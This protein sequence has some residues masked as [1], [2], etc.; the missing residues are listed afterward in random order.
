MW[1]ARPDYS[2]PNTLPTQNRLNSGYAPHGSQQQALPAGAFVNPAFARS[3][4]G[5]LQQGYSV[6]SAQ[7]LV[8]N[9]KPGDHAYSPPRTIAGHKRKLDA[10][11]GP[12]RET[13]P[14]PPAAPVVPAF[15]GSLPLTKASPASSVA[16]KDQRGQSS[17]PARKSL[18]LTPVTEIPQY[19]DSDSGGEDRED[20]EEAAYAEL[21]NKLTFEHNG[22]L[23][24]LTSA[25]DLAAWKSER[26]KRWPT[27]QRMAD[28]YDERREI[29][30]ERKRLLEGAYAY[31][32][33]KFSHTTLDNRRNVDVAIKGS[34]IVQTGP[35][36]PEIAPNLE[37]SETALDRAKRD[38]Q[39]RSKQLEDLRRKVAESEAR[40]REARAQQGF[41][42]AA[43]A[44]SPTVLE[45]S[46]HNTMPLDSGIDGDASDM[47]SPLENA[48]DVQ[49]VEDHEESVKAIGEDAA[50]LSSITSSSSSSADDS[51]DEPPEESS[52]KL[53]ELK[54]EANKDRP[55]CKY[56]A[57]GHCSAGDACRFKHEGPVQQGNETAANQRQNGNA[58]K[59]PRSQ[60][61]HIQS[62]A[63]TFGKKGIFE[64]LLEQE[65]DE[66]DRF[67]LKVIKY[68]GGAGFF[69]ESMQTEGS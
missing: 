57:R 13:L 6:S 10:L 26:R 5:A 18:G 38:V 61:Q 19:P 33:P 43:V 52:S 44:E 53:T 67:A 4:A 40:N 14:R 69:K 35:K 32:R 8:N 41:G 2:N 46:D 60:H 21:G 22:E 51:D 16:A 15:G 37:T 36:Q 55:L 66:E 59:Q 47:R 24:T 29:G 54:S 28:R 30:E 23:M 20:D 1:G 65:Q 68:L 42:S 27:R 7:L 56:F 49:T 62:E 64:R 63:S 48:H 17:Q 11:R 39:Q 34:P 12:P 50:E 25:A 58:D 31:N 45:H 3:D 9:I